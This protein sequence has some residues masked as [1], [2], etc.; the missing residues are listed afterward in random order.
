MPHSFTLIVFLRENELFQ[1]GWGVFV[2]LV[3]IPERSGGHQFPAK[4]ENPGRWG[5]PKWDSLRGGGLDIFWNYTIIIKGSGNINGL[6]NNFLV[7]LKVV[8]KWL[9]H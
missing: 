4:M 9:W 7:Y 8:E 3:E 2:T 6:I 1:R 5:G